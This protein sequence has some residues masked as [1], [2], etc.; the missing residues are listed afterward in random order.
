[1]KI[2]LQDECSDT[3]DYFLRLLA[4]RSKNTMSI[5]DTTSDQTYVNDIN[6]GTPTVVLDDTV[7]VEVKKEDLTP[8]QAEQ[9]QSESHVGKTFAEMEEINKAKQE[10]SEPLAMP[11]SR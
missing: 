2:V 10:A 9:V 3:G 1:M 8:E 4:Y 6:D 5:E 11:L 7:K